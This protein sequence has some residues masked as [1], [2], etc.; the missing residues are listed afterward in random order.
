MAVLQNSVNLSDKYSD[1]ITIKVAQDFVGKRS[2]YMVRVYT[3]GACRLLILDDDL[4]QLYEHFYPSDLFIIDFDLMYQGQLLVLL[5]EDNKTQVREITSMLYRSGEYVQPPS[6]QYG[7]FEGLFS[8]R[9]IYE[10]HL[11][12]GCRQAIYSFQF[13]DTNLAFRFTNIVKKFSVKNEWVQLETR[14]NLCF[15]FYKQVMQWQ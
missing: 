2:Y 10:K 15:L 6:S 7:T 13:D 5:I 14:D 12:V 11:L 8:L 1:E 4:N 3:T 9:G